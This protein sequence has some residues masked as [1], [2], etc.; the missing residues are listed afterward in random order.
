MTGIVF[1]I[2][3]KNLMR[4][5]GKSL[6]IGSILF[7]GTLIM[8]VGNAVISGLDAGLAQNFRQ[9]MTGDIVVVSTAQLKDNVFF[10]PMGE[11][12]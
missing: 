11:P 4:H 8:T 2:A 1:R 6:V 12:V 9:R 10:T 3:W 5:R 7:T